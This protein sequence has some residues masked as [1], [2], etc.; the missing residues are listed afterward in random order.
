MLKFARLRGHQHRIE[1]EVIC[2]VSCVNFAFAFA[3]I[4]SLCEIALLSKFV[5]STLMGASSGE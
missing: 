3:S 2:I 4:M 1:R 5:D